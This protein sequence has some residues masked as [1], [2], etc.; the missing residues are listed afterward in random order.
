MQLVAVSFAG[1]FFKNI[2]EEFAWRGYLTP[3]LKALGVPDLANHLI[4]GAIW[5]AWHIPYWLFLLDRAVIASF[6]SLGL[7]PLVL[8][9]IPAIV[10]SAILYGELRLK[11]GSTWPAM[12]LHT[13][14]N[15][16]TLVLLVDGFV[17]MKSSLEAV[18][19]PGTGGLLG[20][21][22]LTLLGLWVYRRNRT[23]K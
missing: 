6:T 8:V 9:S 20:T 19:T 2:F 12:F 10:A 13:V 18:F 23:A 22:L 21:L 16:L 11:S 14:C 4:T 17:S 1:N 5:T 3:R 7:G 15:A